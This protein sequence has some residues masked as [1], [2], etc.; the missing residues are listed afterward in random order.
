METLDANKHF[1]KNLYLFLSLI[2]EKSMNRMLFEFTPL[3]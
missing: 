2:K 1:F 3:S